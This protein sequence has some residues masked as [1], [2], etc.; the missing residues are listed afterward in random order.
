MLFRSEDHL[1]RAQRQRRGVRGFGHQWRRIEQI[2]N[3]LGAGPSQLGDRENRRELSDRRSDEQQVGREG[4]E[5]ADGDPTLVGEPA[6][7]REHRDLT[8]GRDGLQRGL[9]ARLHLDEPH[10]GCEE[11]GRTIHE[12]IEFVIFL[13]EALDRKSTRLNSSH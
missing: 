5:G 1:T 10:P 9:E 12:A 13:T 7:E 6:A 8:Q 4:E 3:P 2:E 11:P